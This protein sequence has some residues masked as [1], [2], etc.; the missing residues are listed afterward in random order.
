[1]KLTDGYGLAVH[2]VIYI[3]VSMYILCGHCIDVTVLRWNLSETRQEPQGAVSARL[4]LRN[5][6]RTSGIHNFC[7]TL[8]WAQLAYLDLYNCL[9]HNAVV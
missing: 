8:N 9:V 1:M 3:L 2:S 6:I 4:I 5:K 7:H